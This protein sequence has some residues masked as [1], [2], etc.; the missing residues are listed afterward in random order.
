MD[1]EVHRLKGNGRVPN[2]R[3]PLVIYRGGIT[4]PPLEMEAKLRRNE[5]PPDWHTSF[6]MYPKHHFHS[7]AHEL[8]AVT[9]G[10]LNGRFGGHDGIDVM[11]SMG[12]LVVIPA[13]VG[14]FGVSITDDLRL[15]GAFPLGFGI[16]DFRLGYPDEYTRM[17]ARSRRVPLPSMDPLHGAG[18]P[19]V[20]LWA[21]A[22]QGVE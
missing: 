9:R 2:S 13:G 17:V 12:D 10:T 18:G 19:L 4:E 16:H 5:W 7:D 3:F 8:I 6:G 14:H 22:E 20:E 11:L 21:E 15:T 1:I